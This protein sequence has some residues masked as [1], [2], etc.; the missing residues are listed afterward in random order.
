MECLCPR[1]EIIF[2]SN[3]VEAGSVFSLS[4]RSPNLAFALFITIMKKKQLHHPRWSLSHDN[5]VARL[6]TRISLDKRFHGVYVE[7]EIHHPDTGLLYVKPDIIY[8][9]NLPKHID[10]PFG[11]ERLVRVTY[12]EVKWGMSRHCARDSAMKQARRWY[13]LFYN[14]DVFDD[15]LEPNFIF[16]SRFGAERWGAE[17]FIEFDARYDD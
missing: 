9:R 3:K 11:R 12:V 16:W 8:H 4:I 6:A 2:I 13:D 1:Q 17:R 7:E 5:E 10:S 15:R 14:L